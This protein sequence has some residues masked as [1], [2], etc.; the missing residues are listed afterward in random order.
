MAFDDQ[1]R[2]G[3]DAEFMRDSVNPDY[4]SAPDVLDNPPDAEPPPPHVLDGYWAADTAE[5]L[6]QSIIEQEDECYRVVLDSGLAAV[7]RIA[8]AALYSQDPE[9]PGAFDMIQIGSEGGDGQQLRFR[10]NE[11][12]SFLR[13]QITMA[14]GQRAAFQAGVLNTDTAALAMAPTNDAAVN[15]FYG[16]EMPASKERERVQACLAFGA[17]YTWWRWDK[18][19]GDEVEIKELGVEQVPIPDDPN[20][21]TAPLPIYGP[22]GAPVAA[23]LNPWEEFH[24]P[25]QRGRHLWR[26]GRER[27]NKYE[28]MALFPQIA[29]QLKGLSG[30]TTEIEDLIFGTSVRHGEDDLVVRHFYH[31]PI[32]DPNDPDNPLRF[33]R[34]LATVGNVPLPGTD[35]RL[36]VTRKVGLPLSEMTGRKLL[37]IAFGY[38]DWWDILASQQGK[39]AIMSDMLSNISQFGRTSA[40]K[41]SETIMD[42]DKLASGGGVFTLGQGDQAPGFMAPPQMGEIGPYAL[43]RLDKTQESISGMNATYRGEAAASITSGEMAAYYGNQ[44]VEHNSD[45]QMSNSEARKQDAN[46]LADLIMLNAENDLLIQIAGVGERPYIVKYRADQLR[47]VRT[48]EM[49]DVPPMMR[50]ASGR[51]QLWNMIKDVPEEK[52]AAAIMLIT[53]GQWRQLVSDDSAS[54]LRINWENEQLATGKKVAV[55]ATNDPYKDVPAHREL[56]DQLSLNPE[57]NKDAIAATLEHIQ[58]HL[59]VY[60]TADPMMC[61]MLKFQPPPRPDTGAPTPAAQHA[62]GGDGKSPIPVKPDERG[63]ALPDGKGTALAPG[64]LG[65][66]VPQPAQPPAGAAV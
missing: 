15:Y 29:E 27:R 10:V 53:T 32:G 23:V 2:D 13:Q 28:L 64:H 11:P 45:T 20:G 43:G 52:R 40:F 51:W 31:V 55:T 54:F 39:D 7:W 35:G 36:P 21:A 46:I 1:E 8:Y 3:G 30:E 17:G 34:Y 61:T 63:P 24:N 22:S 49:Q 38:S 66:K 62:G 12:A 60:Y 65:S 19:A 47:G 50:S 16:R 26:G 37:N 41:G 5:K 44:A 42:L 56:L 59:S 33:G 57:A 4:A 18:W 9:N 6:A 14:T 48:I 58:E 25:R